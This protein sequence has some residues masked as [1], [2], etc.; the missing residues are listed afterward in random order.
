[1]AEFVLEA[2]PRTVVGKKV[3]ALRREGIVPATIYGPNQEPISVQFNYR[4][5][6]V[7][8]SKAGG[9]N[10]IDIK[11]GGKNYPVLAREVQRD[12]VR[13]DILHVDFLAVDMK[14]KLEVAIPITFINESPAV[15][16]NGILIFGPNTL[17]VSVLPADII[18]E[19]QVDLAPLL[20]IGDE[21]LVGSL[22]LPDSYD[23]IN[24]PHEMLVKVVQPSA[25]RAE[26]AL[27]DEELE[28]ELGGAEQDEDEEQD[29]E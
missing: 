10:L 2:E 8:L 28:F 21:I 29:E 12:V 13:R 6:Y 19:I 25:A 26:E 11:V 14:A 27:E 24:D 1:M 9:T 5:L 18:N 17:T 7:G 22:E 20:E 15:G 4:S 23:I 3:K 16:S